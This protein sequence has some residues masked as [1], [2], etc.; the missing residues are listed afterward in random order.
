MVIMYD[1]TMASA[2]SSSTTEVVRAVTS[3]HW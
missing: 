3:R 1:A 2:A